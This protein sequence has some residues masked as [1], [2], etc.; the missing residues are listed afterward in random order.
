MLDIRT[1][2]MSVGPLDTAFGI[3]ISSKS[4]EHI[5]CFC[6]KGRGIP[7]LLLQ[8]YIIV[9]IINHTYGKIEMIYS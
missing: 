4:V 7:F 3:I 8:K 9:T 5:R 2:K 1:F 6:L